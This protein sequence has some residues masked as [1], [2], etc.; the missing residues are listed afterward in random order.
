MLSKRDMDL[1]RRVT[2]RKG[3]HILRWGPALAVRIDRLAQADLIYWGTDSNYPGRSKHRFGDEVGVAQSVH[4]HMG[5]RIN[6]TTKGQILRK[7]L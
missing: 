1:F 5:I 2:L 3:F 7:K 6:L 4:R